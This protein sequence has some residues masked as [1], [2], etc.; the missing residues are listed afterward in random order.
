MCI[1]ELYIYKPQICM[2]SPNEKGLIKKRNKS[3]F[4]EIEFS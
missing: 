3:N 1:Y 4:L 2:F